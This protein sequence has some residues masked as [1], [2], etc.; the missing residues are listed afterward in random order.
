ML[1]LVVPPFSGV[2]VAPAE[3]VLLRV[4][5]VLSRVFWDSFILLLGLAAKKFCKTLF[6]SKGLAER[7]ISFWTY[8]VESEEDP[9]VVTL[10]GTSEV[11]VSLEERTGLASMTTGVCT[12]VLMACATETELIFAPSTAT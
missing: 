10:L 8:E 2:G 9:V 6:S 3:E 4:M 5:R 12:A 7:D 1:Q 11:G